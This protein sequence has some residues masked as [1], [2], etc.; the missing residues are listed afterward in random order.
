MNVGLIIKDF[1]SEKGMTQKQLAKELS[2]SVK[3]LNQLENGVKY[4][5]WQ[6]LC[7][8]LNHLELEFKIIPKC[9]S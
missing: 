5:R 8:I 2:I 1:R 7:K 6:M 9:N 3:H 4:P